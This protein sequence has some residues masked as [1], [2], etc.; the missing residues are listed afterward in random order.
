[1]EMKNL[2]KKYIIIILLIIIIQPFIGCKEYDVE[3]IENFTHL[4]LSNRILFIEKVDKWDNFHGDGTAIF[5][6]DVK[7][8]SMNLILKEMDMSKWLCLEESS[9]LVATDISSDVIY[10]KYKLEE[11]KGYY[12]KLED[13]MKNEIKV[14]IIDTCN[15]KFIYYYIFL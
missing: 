12:L 10:K 9:N 13:N 6:F 7:K 8:D 14:A 1:M 3:T 15:H 5:L 2:N 11:M 4:K